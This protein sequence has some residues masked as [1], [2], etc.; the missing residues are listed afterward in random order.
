MAPQTLGP[1]TDFAGNS[2]RP[3]VPEDRWGQEP[4]RES[5]VD[6]AAQELRQ[7]NWACGDS[8]AYSLEVRL[9]R[10]HPEGYSIY[11]PALPG[12]VSEGDTRKQALAN[13]GEAL[14]AAIEGYR[15]EGQAIPWVA[16]EEQAQPEAGEKRIWIIVNV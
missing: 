7:L 8:G 11:A 5:I 3:L 12:V 10:E 2:E 4:M 14:Q 1:A 6:P 13:I 16:I 9:C 15:H